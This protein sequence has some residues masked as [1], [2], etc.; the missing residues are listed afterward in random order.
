MTYQEMVACDAA[1]CYASILTVNVIGEM[2]STI[3]NPQTK[4]HAVEW[5]NIDSQ[6]PKK[7]HVDVC[8]ESGHNFV[9]C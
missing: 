1:V 7:F 5:K 4:L 2:W 8:V 6:Q 9:G 3:L